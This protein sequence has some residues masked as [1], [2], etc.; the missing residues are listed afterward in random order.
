MNIPLLSL[1]N[2]SIYKDNFSLVKNISFDILPNETFCVV[3]ESGSGK[4]L[5]A[6]SLLGMLPKQL[7][8]TTTNFLFENKNF[9]NLT[10]KQWQKIRGKE[11]SIIFQDPQSSLNPSMKI[12]KQVEE[13]LKIHTNFNKTER[14]KRVLRQFEK[15]LLPNP[16]H[17][18]TCYPHQISGGQKQRVVI[19]MA[20]ICK[21][22]LLIADEPTTALDTLVQ[23]EIIS[24]IKKLKEKEKMSVFFISHDLNLV[25]QFAD[26]IIVMKKG[27][28]IEQGTTKE[29]F[30]TPKKK[31]TQ[32]LINMRIALEEKVF[33]LP[34]AN[35]KK[36]SKK[37]VSNATKENFQNKNDDKQRKKKELIRAKNLFKIY[38]KTKLTA[39]QNI[40][41]SLFSKETLGIVGGSGC[42]KTTLA[43]ILMLLEKP[44]S[45]NLTYFNNSLSR[46]SKKE[47]K[48]LKKNIQLIFQ[49]PYAALHP[50]KKVGQLINEALYVH[51]ILP[52]VSQRT[53]RTHFLLKQVGLSK[54]HFE[55][56]AY[57]LSGGQRQRVVIARALAVKPKVLICDEAVASL[58]VSIQAQVLNLLNNLKEN[59]NL[60]YIFISHD[61]DVVRYISDRIIVMKKGKII[62]TNTSENIYNAPQKK[63]TKK[64]IDAVPK[65]I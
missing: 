22:K 57:E 35:E 41:F 58:D 38:R 12:G 47:K 27:R 14:K 53:K 4:S 40:N 20:L 3:G 24:L 34:V 64:L 6:L 18:Y 37:I 5:S 59:F 13:V 55:K 10:E 23:K 50:Q 62:E 32:T 31:Y 52:S 17:I 30:K 51:K 16:K 19:A 63:Y 33:P 26:K 21:P 15:V 61:L 28:L 46:R 29:I 7:T 49:D 9:Q 25:G 11:I 2:L 44:S 36:K 48:N 1:K 65:V 56:Y 60:S 8:T 45:G 43:K 54:N 42:G 39:V